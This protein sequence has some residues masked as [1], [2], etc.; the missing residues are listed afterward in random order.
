M[1]Y[2]GNIFNLKNKSTLLLIL[3]LTL[4]LNLILF[5]SII[6]GIPI[7]A[8]VNPIVEAVMLPTSNPIKY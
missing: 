4:R 3:Q 7:I 5:L 6:K 1:E 2:I 8:I